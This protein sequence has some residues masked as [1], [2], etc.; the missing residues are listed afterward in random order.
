MSQNDPCPTRLRQIALI[1]GDIDRAR[2]LLTTILGTEIVFEDPQVAQ[3]GLKNFLVAIGGDIIE[4]CSPFKPD[5][6]V[7]RLLEKRGDGGYMIIMQ[8]IDAAAQ[9]K[10]IESNKWTKVIYSHSHDDAECIQ[11]HPKG[12]PGGMMPELDSHKP[13]PTN[14][15]PLED[16]FSPWHPCG[17]DYEQYSAGMKRCSHLRLLGA[18]CRLSPGQ[19]DTEAAAGLWEKYFGVRRESSDLVFTNA[20]L[21]FVPG[22][23]GQPEG[24]ESVTVE[25]KGKERFDKALDVVSKEGLCGDGWANILGVKWYFVLSSEESSGRVE[26]RS[27]L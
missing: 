15:T 9:R 5:T 7:G 13:S 16:V 24:L 1:A 8:T 21:K 20:R 14:P 3:W 12:I 23:H 18:T 22:V 6:T 11:Y 17:S 25:I 10:K 2:Y 27:R 19:T 4:V 26:E